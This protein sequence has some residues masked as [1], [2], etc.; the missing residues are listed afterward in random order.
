MTKDEGQKTGWGCA[1]SR[2]RLPSVI[3][4]RLTDMRPAQVSFY[5]MG[6][7]NYQT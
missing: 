1:V 6:L 4:F 5:L 7:S 3:T 2:A